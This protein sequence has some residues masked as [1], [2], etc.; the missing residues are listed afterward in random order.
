MNVALSDRDDPVEFFDK[1]PFEDG[2]GGFPGKM[3]VIKRP[4][5][6]LE[7]VVGPPSPKKRAPRAPSKLKVDVDGN[8]LEPKK[9]AAANPKGKAARK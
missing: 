8:V 7:V 9:R 4:N 5:G 1:S 2:P 6:P 3:T